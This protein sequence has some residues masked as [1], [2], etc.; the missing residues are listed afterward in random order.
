M[1]TMT[2]DLLNKYVEALDEEEEAF[3]LY[4][5]I[6]KEELEKVHQAT[7][8]NIMEE[9]KNFIED[10]YKIVEKNDEK[11]R[12]LNK[13]REEKLLE[14]KNEAKEVY[15]EAIDEYKTQKAEI[16]TEAQ[17]TAKEELEESR[18]ELENLSNET[19]EYLKNSMTD[20]AN[21]I[22]EKVIGYRSE[23]SG[24]DTKTIDEILYQ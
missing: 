8:L 11:I 2:N 20:L 4:K 24:Y 10:N 6:F 1:L 7:I 22:V 23:V 9:R 21:D 14:A 3:W 15:N 19:K 5:H 16:I 18:V 12:N 17:N 13:K